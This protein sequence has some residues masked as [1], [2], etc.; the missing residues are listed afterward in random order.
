MKTKNTKYRLRNW[1]EYNRSL[2]RRGSLTLWLDDEVVRAWRNAAKTGK[3]GAS[4]TY[5][6]LAVTCCLS[7]G[8]VF[9]LPLRQ[10][11][12]LVASLLNLLGVSLP[13]P[14]FSTLSRRRPFLPVDLEIEK[15][16]S[17]KGRYIALDSTGLK[18]YGEGEWK[19]KKHG[20][21]KRRTWRKIH[22]SV[23]VE[24][25]EIL[26]C[27]MT[28]GDAAD[29][30]Q[31]KTLIESSES[32]GGKIDKVSADGAYDSWAIDEYLAGKKIEALIPPCKGSKIRQRK[33]TGKPPLPRDERLR[34][35]RRLG[36]GDF[37]RGRRLWSKESGY[38]LRSLSETCMMRQKCVLGPGLRSRE[39]SG[40]RVECLLRCRVLNVLTRLGMPDSHAFIPSKSTG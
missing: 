18:I 7:L 3:R 27:E 24:T 37:E 30:P 32:V 33:C 20:I 5:S 28:G 25:G 31:L 34:S 2:I 10:S 12:G 4:K 19:V 39:E 17:E 13:C 8:L 6:D 9:K 40:Q 36:Y 38:S 22:L 26:A 23:D 21:G 35:I 11:C 15:G 29:A 16:S 1:K 14:H